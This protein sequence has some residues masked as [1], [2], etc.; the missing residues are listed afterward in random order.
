M[1][2]RTRTPWAALAAAAWLA[3]APATAEEVRGSGFLESVDATFGT[4]VIQGEPYA[5]RSFTVIANESGGAVPL[6][7]LP[8]LA[9]GASSDE[10]AIWYEA[11]EANGPNP[12][13]LLRLH[14]TGGP[15][16]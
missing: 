3:S 15:P 10:A 9:A 13:P 5:V 6:E 2:R 12:R 8:N 11:G 16:R 1:M 14:L 4:V 7:E